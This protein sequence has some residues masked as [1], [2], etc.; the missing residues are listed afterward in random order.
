MRAI[1]AGLLAL[2]LSDP[3]SPPSGPPSATR[4]SQFV[5]HLSVSAVDARGQLVADLTPADFDVRESGRP[6]GVDS[7]RFVRDEPRLIGVFLDEYHV[8]GSS[9]VRVREAMTQFV[10]ALKPADQLVVMKPLDS[11]LSIQLS[12]DR[13]HAR[14][15]IDQFE[16]RREM[17]APRNAYERNFIAGSP[18][19]I[20]AARTQV[21]LSAVNALAVHLGSL[22]DARKTLIVVTEDL[23]RLNRRRGQESMPALETILRSAARSNV[24]IYPFDPSGAS[25]V[26]EAG[27]PA[28]PLR[29]LADETSGKTIDADAGL[30]HAIDDASGYYVL[31][32]HASALDDGHFHET[33]IGVKRK[34][35]RIQ[36]ARGYWAP[37]PDDTLRAAVLAHM[38]EPK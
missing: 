7:A 5:V 20:E 19:R 37:S 34:G 6:Q 21:A 23:P 8:G 31:T 9:T 10:D 11:V 16:G 33:E 26:A 32:F 27:Q 3:Q 38:N 1:V 2:A 15:T 24:S 4:N 22:G 28:D 36:A 14:E 17:L 25:H 18:E 35:V 30:L 29:R 12:T 13:E